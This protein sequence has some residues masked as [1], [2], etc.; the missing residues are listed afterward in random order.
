MVSETVLLFVRHWHAAANAG[1][2]LVNQ[3]G[4]IRVAD[5]HATEAKAGPD[6]ASSLLFGACFRLAKINGRE[7][8]EVTRDQ[9]GGGGE[10]I[11][12]APGRDAVAR[13]T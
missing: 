12:C 9:L 6:G 13:A 8:A 1:S 5:L 3:S 2:I 11:N 4:R 10:K 7:P